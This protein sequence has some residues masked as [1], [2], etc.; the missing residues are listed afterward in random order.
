MLAREGTRRRSYRSKAMP[1]DVLGAF[2]A[3]PRIGPVALLGT[4]LWGCVLGPFEANGRP[5][6]CGPGYVC[7]DDVCRED[8][9]FDAGADDA[10]P[11]DGGVDAFMIRDAGLAV[12]DASFDA[13]LPDAGDEPCM[14]AFFCDGFED[15]WDAWNLGPWGEAERVSDSE[16]PDG[17]AVMFAYNPGDRAS[18]AIPEMTPQEF[19]LRA[20]AYVPA[21]ATQETGS[22]SF[23]TAFDSKTSDV[24]QRALIGV[25]NNVAYMRSAG[26]LI[27]ASAPFPTDRWVCLEGHFVR[28]GSGTLYVDGER[29]VVSALRDWDT[30]YNRISVGFESGTAA[31]MNED[32][33]R[34]DAVAYS[35]L[36]PGCTSEAS[37]P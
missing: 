7:I 4:L 35:P 16:A 1:F 3:A 28:G 19:W 29:V 30:S 14:G 27:Q 9:G 5:C 32:G 13:S 37:S 25:R 24:T 18:T 11:A 34:F 31:L 8:D 22:Y 12:V 17:E 20:W 21:G 2:G 15:G 36:R 33:M 26:T 10:G 6:P 23:L